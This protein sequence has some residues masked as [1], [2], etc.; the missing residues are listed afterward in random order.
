MNNLGF[1]GLLA[2][3]VVI[4]VWPVETAMA[5]QGNPV[6]TG[7]PEPP[8]AVLRPALRGNPAQQAAGPAPGALS[9]ARRRNP[10]RSRRLRGIQPL[11]V[12]LFTSKN[13]YKDKAS[14]MDPRYFA[15]TRRARWSRRCGRAD[16]LAPIRRPRPRG[17][18]AESTIRAT[19]S[20]APIPIRQP[21]SIIR[22]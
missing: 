20:S 1:R 9:R 22:P 13:F 6:L 3:A 4:G 21:R 19:G 8:P 17:A 2:A 11:P 10:Y 5:Q 16:G 7:Q 14:W 12:D 18:I 15:A